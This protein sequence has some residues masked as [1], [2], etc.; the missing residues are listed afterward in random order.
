MEEIRAVSQPPISWDDQ[1]GKWFDEEFAH[2]EKRRSYGILSRRQ[3]STA[4]IPRPGRIEV[5]VD[6][7]NTFGV[8]FDTSLSMDREIIAKGLG[9]IIS[10]SIAKD[11]KRIRLVYCDAIPYDEGYIPVD[12]LMN[13]VNVK[14]RGG[15]ILQPAVD[16]SERDKSFPK[17]APILIVTDGYCDKLTVTAP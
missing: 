14:G 13:Y 9:S 15:T 5:P 16:L 2:I 8:V 3:Y 11:I 4:D 1:L 12:D 6:Y 7:A 10:Y 17:D